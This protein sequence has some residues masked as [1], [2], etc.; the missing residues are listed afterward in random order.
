MSQGLERERTSEHSLNISHGRLPGP[1]H[2]SQ[3]GALRERGEKTTDMSAPRAES[4]LH[5]PSG[6]EDL[7]A[8]KQIQGFLDLEMLTDVI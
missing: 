4:R 1:S 6:R 8:E 3:G 7:E 5:P 2:T